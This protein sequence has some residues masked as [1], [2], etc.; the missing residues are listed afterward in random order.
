MTAVEPE[1]RPHLLYVADP[2]CS[3]CYGFAPVIR[4]LAGHFGERLPVRLLM[5]GLRA[6]NTRPMR[7]EDKDYIRDAWTRVHAAT[8]QPF[9]FAF[10]ER[11]GFVY[12]TEPACRAVVTGRRLDPSRALTL[13]ERIETAFY[14]QNRDVTASDT[15]AAVAGEAGYDTAAFSMALLSPESRNETFRDFLLAQE[16]GIRGFPTLLAATGEE[17]RYALVTSG[18]RPLDGLLEALE[19]WLEALPAGRA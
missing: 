8:G 6:G 4:A 16:L 12:D 1:R 18:C 7:P 3:W 19:A 14:A 17:D 2:M 9:A 10:F 11:E 5:G 15:L 13:M